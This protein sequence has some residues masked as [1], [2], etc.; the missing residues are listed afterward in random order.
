M[1]SKSIEAKAWDNSKGGPEPEIREDSGKVGNPPALQLN[2]LEAISLALAE[3]VSTVKELTKPSHI[4]KR[5]S[6][7]KMALKGKV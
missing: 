1:N 3:F 4:S 7:K 2:A 5:K 6:K